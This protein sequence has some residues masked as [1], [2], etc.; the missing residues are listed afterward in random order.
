MEKEQKTRPV[1][2]GEEIRGTSSP[3]RPGKMHLTFSSKGLVGAMC[4]VHVFG[5]HV[6]SHSCAAG[7]GGGWGR[8]WAPREEALP[9]VSGNTAAG[10]SLLGIMGCLEVCPPRVQLSVVGAAWSRWSPA[11]WCCLQAQPPP[12]A[13]P[14]CP[15]AG[16]T[17]FHLNT[18]SIKP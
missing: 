9:A 8:I 1:R 4:R 7:W 6:V 18:F 10:G 2:N 3:K 14:H 12:T 13:P 16:S 5:L 11:Q 15:P 17:Q